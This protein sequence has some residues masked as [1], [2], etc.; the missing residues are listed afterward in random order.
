MK[1]ACRVS[2]LVFYTGPPSP[3][4]EYHAEFILSGGCEA[5]DGARPI[6]QFRASD[7]HVAE[8]SGGPVL[9]RF[10]G[11]F[12]RLSGVMEHH[13]N[14]SRALGDGVQFSA[15]ELAHGLLVVDVVAKE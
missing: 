11:I 3:L 5:D 1:L 9:L 13:P 14:D 2:G 12:S 7:A 15:E 4:G 10:S 6:R 8:I